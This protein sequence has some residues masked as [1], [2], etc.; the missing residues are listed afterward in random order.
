[1]PAR[2]VLV[3]AAALAAL[4]AAMPAARAGDLFSFA[5]PWDDGGD[6]G[7]TDLSAWNDKPAGKHGVVTVADGHLMAGPQRLRLF[8]VNI[9][10]GSVAPTR[11]EADT[12]ARRLARFGVNIVRF[13]HMDTGVTPR[14]ILLKD[15]VTFDPAVMDRLDYF[16]AALKREGIY[17]NINLHVGRHYPGFGEIW[18][19]GPQ[20]WKGIDH[21]LPGMIAQQKD[22]ARALLTHVNPY[23]GTAY[24]A[25][26]AVALVEVN[27]ENGL[28]RSWRDGKLDGMP[29]PMR[30]EL[31]RQWRAW[32]KARYGDDRALIAAW[33]LEA[34]PLGAE[35]LSPAVGVRAGTPG[36]SLQV[37]GEAKARLA[38]APG[39]LTLALD[40]AGQEIWHTQLHQ[41]RLAFAADAPYTLTLKLR[42]DRP[43]RV[44]VTA[45]QAH[46]PWSRLWDDTIEAGPNW[47]TVT[48]P[49][50]PADGDDVA[51]LTLTGLGQTTGTL[52]VADVSLRPGGT[53]GLPEG[54]SL[55]ADTLDVLD[56]ARFLARTKPAQRD[57]LAFLWQTETAYWREMN[58]FLKQ[59][60]AVKAPILG[61]QVSYSPA[62]IQAGFDVVDGHAYWQHPIFPGK[63]WDMDNWLIR[64]TPMAGIDGGGT[65]ADLALRRVAGKPF[66]VTE[67]NH[68]AP[69]L[70]Q[71]EAMP[72]AAAY[73]AL[74][75]WDGLFLYSFG[76]HD[77][78]W[79]T[80]FISNF[81]D[82]RANPVKLASLIPA[83][84]LLRRADIAAAAPEPG[85]VPDTAAWIE[86]LRR[87]A[88]VPGADSFGAPRNAA[89]QRFV[90]AG[91]LPAAEPPLPV[92][93]PGGALVWGVEGVG[94]RTV[95]LDT[96]L[97]KALIGARLGRPFDAHGVTL[98]V[99]HAR[100]DWAVLTATVVSGA[101]FAAPGRVLVTALGQEENT[102]QPWR[103]A[104][105]T[106]TGR[107]FGRAPVLVEG[108]GARVT[109]PVPAARVAAWALDERGRRREPLPVTGAERAT[110]EIGER[111]KTLW[112]EVEIR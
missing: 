48:L 36:W 69:S 55:A 2:P 98:E 46:A 78:D 80:D 106:T 52:E 33:G 87:A 40:A 74:Q 42:A 68:P 64:N 85:A 102:A 43:M 5:M 109:L 53:L 60:L 8:G 59:D 96:P 84:A 88:K 103:D 81:F 32:L 79:R 92:A 25:E 38:A 45:M 35:M 17:A 73:G 15:R 65:I 100:N 99:T 76:A 21:F 49:F 93:S 110:V 54:E 16:I 97:S 66:I 41:T 4:A 7:V 12:L 107:S 71:G 91:T 20:Y 56:R 62:P 112:Y 105:K 14:G 10:F 47:R 9:V 22:Y 86:A 104:A 75:D 70:F 72:L 1:M 108:V 3:L 18:A 57:W 51:R 23:T 50:A 19:D 101:D 26:P 77:L 11:E 28:L 34:K 29:A 63:P 95:T 89:L 82:S 30:A 90:S 31:A 37:I 83:A 24:T 27:N 6:G 94:G 13:H 111:W 58:R 39:G 67:Y 61:T 44:G